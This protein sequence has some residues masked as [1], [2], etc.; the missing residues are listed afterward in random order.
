MAEQKLDESDR[1]ILD[2][3]K[4]DARQ[5]IAEISDQLGI[6]RA[7]VHERIMRMKK[8]GV[9]RRFTIL[10]DHAKL[11]LP[12][13]SFVFAEYDRHSKTSLRDVSHDLAKIKGVTGVY[14]LGGEWSLL[15]KVRAKDM[16][17]MGTL[18]LDRIGATPGVSKTCAMPCFEAAKEEC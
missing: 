18:V 15:I 11:G 17:Q 7:T 4:R 12:T 8:A 6:P 9:I 2:A 13:L 1:Y 14:I 5:T 10:E 3:L 16:E